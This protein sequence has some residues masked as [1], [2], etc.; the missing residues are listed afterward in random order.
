[1]WYRL[2]NIDKRYLAGFIGIIY[3]YYSRYYN[4]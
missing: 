4:K 1:M 3:K 2:K